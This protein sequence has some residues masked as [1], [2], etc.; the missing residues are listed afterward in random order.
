MA[1]RSPSLGELAP[2]V[3]LPKSTVSRLLGAVARQG[4][5]AQDGTRGRF[6]VGPVLRRV[7]QRSLVDRYLAELGQ[8]PLQALA[9]P[10][11]ETVNLAVPGALGVEHLEKVFGRHFLA[12]GGGWGAALSRRLTETTRPRPHR[13]RSHVR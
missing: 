7:E 8:P 13:E 2:A 3:K 6:S 11:G 10:S 12:P 9:E 1:G 4:L 5:V